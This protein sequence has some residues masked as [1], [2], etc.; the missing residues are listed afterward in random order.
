[1][2]RLF[3]VTYD[4]CNQRRLRHVHKLM[5]GYGEWIQYSIF[6]CQLTP[7]DRAELIADLELL[8]HH[9]EDHVLLFD[10]GCASNIK[11]KVTSLGKTYTPPNDDATII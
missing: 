9:K 5:R 6:Q 4:I 11:P 8:I 10:L 2:Q 3:L 7:K 1:M